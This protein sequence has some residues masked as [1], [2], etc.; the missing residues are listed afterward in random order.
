MMKKHAFLI[1]FL[2][3]T[4]LSA[5][6]NPFVTG[7]LP[8]KN[9]QSEPVVPS[10]PSE[11]SGPSGPSEPSGPSGPSGPSEPSE[12]SGPSEPSEPSGPSAIRI[13]I[14]KI[15]NIEGDMVTISQASGLPG[16][17]ITLDYTLT[18]AKLHNRLV[19]SGT[20]ADIEAVN[21]AGSGT[22]LY[23]IDEEDSAEGAINI[24]AVFTHTD[25]QIDT[26]AFADNNNETRTYGDPDFTKAIT[27]NGSGTGAITY[28]SGD[29]NTATVN[30][31]GEVTILGAGTA[32]I[33]AVKAADAYYEMAEAVYT[34]TVTHLQLT[35]T[36]PSVTTT[37]VYDGSTTAAVTAGGLKNIIGS[38]TVTVS[39][40][41]SYNS[42]N[43][44]EANLITVVY[45]ISG[46][47]AGNYLKPVNFTTAGVITKAQG[48][49]A[50][51]PVAASVTT[52]SITINAVT[53]PNNGQTVE[54]SISATTSVTGGW[55]DGLVFGGLSPNTDYYVFAR[56]KANG[57]YLE[58][59]AVSAVI[60]TQAVAI[61]VPRFTLID[62]E[63]DAIGKTYDSTKAGSAP[64]VKVA[65]DPLNSG[66]K[67]LQ[68]TSTTYNQAAVV[69][70]NLPYELYNYK[71]FSFRFNLL[72]GANLTNQSI[73]VYVAK[74]SSDFLQYGF[75]NPADSSYPK[76]ADKLLGSTTAETIGDNHRNKWTSYTLTIN[77]PGAAIKDLKGDIY[78]AIGINCQN[79]ADYMFDDL[80]FTMK[81]DYNPPPIVV[82]PQPNPPSIGAVSSGNYR[83][84]FKE[85]GKTDAEITAKVNTTWNKLFNGSATEK[86][87]YEVAPDM[88]YI[89]DSGNND[90]RSEGMSYGMMMCVQ[91]DKK[92]EFDRLW[93]WAKT[94][95]Y[96]SV[97]N[98]KNSRGYFAWQCGTDG[99]KKDVNPAPD[100]EFYFVTALLFASARWGDGTGDFAYGKWARQVLYDMLHR[101]MAK[102]DPYGEPPMFNKSNN[103]VYFSP[104]GGGLHT[105][106]SYHLP[107]FYEVWALELESDYN[108]NELSGIWSSKA[109]LKT[110]IDF[111]K[112]AAAASRTF[113]PNTTNATT[114][115][116]PDYANF[117]GSPTG[118]EHADFRYDAWRIAMNIAMDY[119]WW[120]KDTWQ[121]TF[122]D[123]IQAFFYSK[124]VTSY[125]SLWTLNGTQIN[126]DHSPGLVACNAVASL[127][128]TH[129]NAWK[130][131]ENFWDIPMTSGQYRYY[132]GCLYMLGLLHVSGNFKAYLSSNTAPVPSSS[133][134]PTSASFD[135]KTGQ[136]ADITVTMT[137]NGNTLTNIKNGAATLTSGTNYTVSGNTVTIKKEYLA[138]QA[139]GTT[140]LVFTFSAGAIQNLVITV[141]DTSNSSISPTT[142]AFDKRSDLQADIT[143]T[144][145]LNGNTLT[146]ISN[147]G[148]TLT[149]GTNYTVSGSTVTIN[150]TYLAAQAVGTTTLVFTFNAGASQNLV[151]TVKESP[152]GG[153]TGTSYNF[154][155]DTLPAG[156]P[157]YSDPGTGTM[158]AVVTGGVLRIS[159][160]NTNHSTPWVIISFNLGAENLSEYTSIKISIRGVSNDFNN[161]AIYVYLGSSRIESSSN[162]TLTT[163]FQDK[164]LTLTGSRNATGSIEL[165]F[166]L[167]QSQDY[168][169]EIASIQL[170]K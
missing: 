12:P 86:I 163:S 89:L 152:A 90:V 166:G 104:Y 74:N 49:N 119:A 28:S 85:W 43:A 136:Q 164:T 99:S 137:L 60:R 93:K 150:K 88:A 31:V 141:T 149:S 95:M 34:L 108:K 131:L 117:D 106:P 129:E 135:K 169:I 5:C 91:L 128:A 59:T 21:S 162:A 87:Y 76:F 64:T 58:G 112:A 2:I 139:V 69:P 53:A 37:K 159:K 134:S 48:A 145:T 81:D 51:V 68:V 113:F 77:N 3:M 18:N 40:A 39:A 116:G 36:D 138:A 66:Q 16:D 14:N 11:P 160:T 144:M 19:F 67:S 133:I 92:T 73:M 62:F 8:N 7:I 70:V 55:Q 61:D 20:K 82:L 17:E 1:T 44:A 27:K 100:G 56:T 140:T 71:S 9:G 46:A 26:I 41:A 122:A 161:K 146:S 32:V 6:D 165:G 45:T 84:M 120:A 33:T 167:E 96:N 156:Y 13:Q 79:G 147:G 153:G 38:D 130:F 94:N 126:A 115:L 121:K 102:G 107:A 72:S 142:A 75:G 63:A 170:I 154:A 65:A 97:N 80:T 57:N 111:Y 110:D 23:V 123:R 15:G 101:D 105:D 50:G 4:L 24:N 155:T 98:G 30:G 35:V 109:D 127:A 124:G 54:Y 148:T 52:D 83:N 151:I 25:K 157:K 47:S 132:D 158:T 103:I 168:T 42:A 118:G 78:I 10:D 29:T 22:K 143:V 125:G 114:G